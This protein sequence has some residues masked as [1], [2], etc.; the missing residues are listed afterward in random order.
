MSGE[1][2]GIREA[3][4]T[5]G[6]QDGLLRGEGDHAFSNVSHRGHL[7]GISQCACRSAAVGN[8]DDRGNVHRL[9][10]VAQFFETAEEDGQT[11]PPAYSDNPHR[12][13]PFSTTRR[14]LRKI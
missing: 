13:S 9:V 6:C 12:P 3:M 2:V 14:V 7:E 8:G 10:I 4:A 5:D 1:S 11:C